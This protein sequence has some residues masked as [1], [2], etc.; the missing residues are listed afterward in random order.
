M[1]G[2][3]PRTLLVVL[4]VSL[5]DIWTLCSMYYLSKIFL[6]FLD[7]I[8]H[9]KTFTKHRDVNYYNLASFGTWRSLIVVLALTFSKW[10]YFINNVLETL[11]NRLISS[12]I[13]G[14]QECYNTFHNQACRPYLT[15]SSSFTLDFT[16]QHTLIMILTFEYYKHNLHTH[17]H[18]NSNPLDIYFPQYHDPNM[19]DIQE[20]NTATISGPNQTTSIS[21]L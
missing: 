19:Y 1:L 7:Y 14:L 4:G 18:H 16:Y 13:H 3:S 6:P 5:P 11:F 21:I 17:D 20:V 9:F 2:S 12:P 15:L 8:W 10:A